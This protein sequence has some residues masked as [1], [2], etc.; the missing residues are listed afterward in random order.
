MK[1]HLKGVSSRAGKPVWKWLQLPSEQGVRMA[2]IALE[3]V[4]ME[5]KKS[6]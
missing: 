5:R 6:V 3:V 2:E 4:E 1:A